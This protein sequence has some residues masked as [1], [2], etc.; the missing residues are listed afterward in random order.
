M[1]VN[2]VYIGWESVSEVW[3]LESVL[4]YRLSYTSSSNFKH[5]YEDVIRAVA[6][7]S[8]DVKINIDNIVNRL[9]E[10]SDDVCFEKLKE[11]QVLLDDNITKNSVNK[12]EIRL[13]RIL[14]RLE[15]INPRNENES[16][17]KS[18]LLTKTVIYV[19]NFNSKLELF[20]NIIPVDLWYRDSKANNQSNI[21]ANL[22]EEVKEDVVSG[23]AGVT[24][25]SFENL[26]IQDKFDFNKWGLKQ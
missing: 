2:E 24:L 11:T 21:N 1:C 13:C 17:Q 23:N 8:G 6:E 16:E 10:K 15:K 12:I 18:K 3:S 4:N 5:F 20:T 26:L 25:K 22:A 19:S 9:S 14:I 7:M